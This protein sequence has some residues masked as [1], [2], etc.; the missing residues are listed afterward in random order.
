MNKAAATSLVSILIPLYNHS[1]YIKRCLD[2]ILEDGYPRIEIIITDDGSSDDSVALAQQWYAEQ[3]TGRIERFELE[4]RPNKGVTRT[5]NELI[6]KAHGDCLVML[7]SDDYL[8]PGGIA[9]RLEYFRSHPTKLA[10][11]GDCIVVDGSGKK[12]HDSG[13]ADLYS[14]H[15]ENLICEDLL[16]LELI[17]NWCVPGPGF[18]AYRKLFDQIGFYDENLTVEDWDLYLRIAARSLLGFIP[19]PVAAY[20]YHGGNSILNSSTK[21]S[22]LDSLMQTA[23]KNS[24]SYHGLRRYGL[25]AKYFKFKKD[26]AELR[27]QW[28]T[29]LV[30]HIAYK[31]LYWPSI[32]SY[33]MVI[34]SSRIK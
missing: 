30:S 20:R 31:L 33:K 27:G 10:V 3:E 28:L 5:V 15:I 16:A 9:A 34:F 18:M 22:H 24:C 6:T 7:A 1:S 14:G 32:I 19:V 17:F 4:S 29:K 12:S 2:S 23:L 21:A 25:I 11:F 8:L 13:I 26:L